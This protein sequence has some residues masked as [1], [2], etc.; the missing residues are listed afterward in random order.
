VLEAPF[1]E[2]EIKTAIFTSY[3]DGA[4]GPDGPY[5]MFYQRFWALVKQ[6]ILDLFS[7]LKREN[8]TFTC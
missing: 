1:S 8:L 3:S 6:D 4:L 7:D 5:F 2:E